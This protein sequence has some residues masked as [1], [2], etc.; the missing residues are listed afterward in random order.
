MNSSE[1]Q[2]QG[3]LV[4]EQLVLESLDPLPFQG[5]LPNFQVELGNWTMMVP[6][7]G[8]EKGE[9]Q[10]TFLR[11]VE[12][13]EIVYLRLLS[14]HWLPPSFQLEDGNQEMTNRW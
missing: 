3:P 13:P 10:P 14:F 11:F 8:L 2:K 9:A 4:A 12:P 6:I 7:Y 1:F 5:P